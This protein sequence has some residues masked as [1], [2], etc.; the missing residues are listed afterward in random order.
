M[1][2]LIAKST[3]SGRYIIEEL[4]NNKDYRNPDLLNK[5]V[6]HFKIS[7]HGSEFSKEVFDP[8]TLPEEDRIGKW[9]TLRLRD[10]CAGWFAPLDMLASIAVCCGVSGLDI[11]ATC[12]NAITIYGCLRCSLHQHAITHQASLI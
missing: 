4:R 11:G 5:L 1:R 10:A 7:Q 6:E 3:S 2:R 9:G 8:E 12:G